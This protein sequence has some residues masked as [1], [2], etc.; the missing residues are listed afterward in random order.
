MGDLPDGK[1]GVPI[2]EGEPAPIDAFVARFQIEPG[3]DGPLQGT[4][5][6]AKDS[7]DVAGWPTGCGNPDWL[8]THT[9]PRRHAASVERLLQAGAR[10]VGKT[11]MDELAYSLEGRN[12]HS[13]APRNPAA[14]RRLTGGSSCGAA[15]AVAGGEIDVGLASD[16]AG[17]VRVPAAWCGLVGMRPTHGRVPDPGLAPLAPSFDTVG[18][19]TRSVALAR[20]V[21]SVLLRGAV[22]PRQPVCLLRDPEVESLA[23]DV[24]SAALRHGFERCAAQ[25]LPVEETTLGID[26]AAGADALRILQGHEVWDTLGAW[27]ESVNPSLGPAVA[28]RVRVARSITQN[29]VRAAAHGRT[30]LLARLDAALPPGRILC[31]PTVPGPAP[32]R[33]ATAPE[34][35][36]LRAR[37]FP[38]TALA[39]LS[40]RPQITLPGLQAQDAPAGWSLL[41]WRG[42]DEALMDTAERLSDVWVMSS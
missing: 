9:A 5:F 10:L 22:P 33:D 41:G 23:V 1:A 25:G 38:L 34:L 29:D 35:Q 13:G 16:T 4:C 36:A 31:L 20:T 2:L 7:F 27:I 42:G 28:E 19:M 15:S 11:C 3:A 14:P 26:P 37:L 40:G 21:G 17:S 8:A 32:R 30:A 18:W 24:D 6:A 12:F 39:S